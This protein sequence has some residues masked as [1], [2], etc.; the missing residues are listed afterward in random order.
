GDSSNFVKEKKGGRIHY[1][2][3]RPLKRTALF[4]CVNE[5]IGVDES[6]GAVELDES[7]ECIEAPKRGKRILVID[8]DREIV[9]FVD[10][11]LS[12]EGYDVMCA[13]DAAEGLELVK[14][15]EIGLV[16]LD[17]AMPDMDGLTACRKMRED[18]KLAGLRIYMVTAKADRNTLEAAARTGADGHII[19]PFRTENFVSAVRRIFP[20]S[21]AGM[22][23]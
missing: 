17:I 8:D 12:M 15:P 4:N 10:R 19:K 20:E 14:D 6:M 5:A 1:R 9:T 2:I 22:S 11:V 21:E 23:A 3:Q 13:E 7:M 16:L 18:P